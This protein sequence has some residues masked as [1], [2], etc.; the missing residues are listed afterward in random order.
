MKRL[1][2]LVLA[3]ALLAPTSFGVAAQERA[4]TDLVAGNAAFALDLYG[5]L[6]QDTEGNLLISPYSISQAL[7]MT[8]AGADG[9]TAEQ[10]AQTMHFTLDQAELPAAFQTLNGVLVSRGTAGEDPER[11]ESARALHIANGLWGEQT[12]PFD[13]EFS[14][15]L[16]QYYGAGLQE[17]DFVNAPEAAA[18]EINDWVA[19]QTEDRIQN[20]VPPDAITPLT[21]LVLANAIYFYGGWEVE[22]NPRLTENDDFFRL[23]GTSASVPFMTKERI[24]PYAPGDGY[25]AVELPYAGSHFAFTVILPDDGQFS[26]FEDGLDAATLE[27]ALDQLGDRK[28]R[29]YLPKFEFEFATGLVEPL[30][31]LGMTDAFDPNLADFSGMLGA[32]APEPLVISNVL[33]KAFIGVDEIGTEAAAVTAIGSDAGGAAPVEEEEPIEVRIDRPFLFA[34]RD[35]ETGTILFLGRVMDPSATT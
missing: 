35:T 14:A 23:D 19:E 31:S 29:V 25:Q 10:M 33:H 34:I 20:I 2:F 3:L 9:Q 1:P 18:E 22:F 28:V 17:T 16:A 24:L 4:T 15:Q 12:F 6:R 21:R 26:A 13:P 30:Q 32:G 5:R 27:A 8:Y 11:G 7:A